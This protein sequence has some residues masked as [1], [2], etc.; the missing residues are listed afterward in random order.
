MFVRFV[1]HRL[2]PISGKRTGIFQIVD[3]L[4][5]SG[6]VE[7]IDDERLAAALA[8][9][10]EHLDAPDRFARGRSPHRAPR[11]ICW[12]KA[13]ASEHLARMREIA[14]ILESYGMPVEMITSRRPGYV[15]YED[16]YQLA[17]CPFS[18]T[19]T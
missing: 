4:R 16:A 12:F 13:S 5:R 7:A 1:V 15:T 19:P 6:A 18:D 2:D 17:A 14:R 10:G 3:R 8:W 11:A 9:F